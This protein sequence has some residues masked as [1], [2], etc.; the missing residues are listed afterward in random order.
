MPPSRPSPSAVP[1]SEVPGYLKISKIV[2]WALY[3]FV[4]I[5]IIALL[6]RTLLLLLGANATAGFYELVMNISADYLQ[7]FRGI[8][9]TRPVGETGYLDV[10][11]LFAIVVYLFILWGVHSLIGYVQNHIDIKQAE[12][13]K[14]LAEIKRQ[15]ELAAMKSQKVVV[16]R[17]V[18]SS[19]PKRKV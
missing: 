18:R 11:A 10:S 16:E 6:F 13:E 8:F 1:R 9:P 15:K 14:Q 7:P 12:Q 4:L 17:T 5:G 3:F 19:T 2:V